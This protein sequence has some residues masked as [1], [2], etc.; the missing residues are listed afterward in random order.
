MKLTNVLYIEDDPDTRFLQAR[1][2]RK[3][4]G[5][6]EV[7]SLDQWDVLRG[8]FE[9]VLLDFHLGAET[10]LDWIPK[11]SARFQDARIALLS[12]VDAEHPNV[13]QVTALGFQSFSKPM[14]VEDLI[15]WTSTTVVNSD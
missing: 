2:W 3:F 1:L 8:S 5:H 7:A 13:R 12:N 14:R 11:I 9:W 15:E 4:D 10:A 6:V